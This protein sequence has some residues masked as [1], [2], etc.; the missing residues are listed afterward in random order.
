VCLDRTGIGML[1][2]LPRE[3]SLPTAKSGVT[4]CSAG[5]NDFEQLCELYRHSIRCNPRGFIQ[6]FA[7]HGG[8][9]EKIST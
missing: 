7:F 4:I 3:Y 9:G 1:G 6:D 8:L 2:T 5:R